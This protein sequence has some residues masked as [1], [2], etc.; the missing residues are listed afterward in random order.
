MT[1]PA[2]IPLGYGCGTSGPDEYCPDDVMARY[3]EVNEPD[4]D[5]ADADSAPPQHEP[6]PRCGAQTPWTR[7]ER[8]LAGGRVHT[9]MRCPV[10][11]PIEYDYEEPF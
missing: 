3:W 10:C 11:D 1:V 7:N 9:T 2:E 5:P 4:P 6:C 8:H